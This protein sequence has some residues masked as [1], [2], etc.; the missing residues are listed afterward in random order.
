MWFFGIYAYK[1][2]ET[3]VYQKF[4]E[5]ATSGLVAKRVA[6]HEFPNFEKY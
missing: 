2:H 5:G 6:S 1:L 3:I 4:K